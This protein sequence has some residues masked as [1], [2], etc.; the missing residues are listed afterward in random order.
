MFPKMA[1]HIS[2]T[3]DELWPGTASTLSE[4]SPGTLA[5]NISPRNIYPFKLENTPATEMFH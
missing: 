5:W 2:N 4:R 1:E 3:C